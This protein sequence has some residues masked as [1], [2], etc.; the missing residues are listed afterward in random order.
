M[1]TVLLWKSH[2]RHKLLLKARVFL[3]LQHFWRR[4]LQILTQ[5][6]LDIPSH[7]PLRLQIA[8]FFST[9]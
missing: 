5:E 4:S 2:I 8:V 1:V 9:G 6:M 7:R 3:Y